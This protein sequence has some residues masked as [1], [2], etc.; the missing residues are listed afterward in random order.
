MGNYYSDYSG[1]D[2]NGDGIGDTDIPY[3]TDGSG[4]SYPLMATSDN[5]NVQAWYLHS[6]NKMY[7]GNMGK[8]P[9]IV[10]LGA[11]G[12]S[13]IW[14]SDEAAQCDVTFS[15]SSGWMGQ[16]KFASAPTSEDTFIV[17]IGYSTDGSDFTAGGPDA[18]LTGDGSKTA[19]TYTTD[20]FSV[21]VPNTK[22]LAL[23]LTN[24][25]DSAYDVTTGGAWSYTSN[26]D[27]GAPE[28]PTPELPTV[29]LVGVGLTV[30]GIFIWLKRR[31]SQEIER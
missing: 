25:S 9:G 27:S 5:Y 23:K 18:T 1:S 6:D 26:P 24:S 14:I 16:V 28:W 4:D 31:K 3:I 15:A 30:L 12:G 20:A 17:E 2:T 29:I 21:T 13:N 10:T 11:S 8:S 7:E 22:Y 19:F